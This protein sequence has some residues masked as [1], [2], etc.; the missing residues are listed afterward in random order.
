MSLTIRFRAAAQDE[1]DAAVAWY[2]SGRTGLGDQFAEAVEELLTEVANSPDRYPVIEGDIHEAPVKGFP[3]C[4]YYRVRG[5]TLV[6]LAVY[7]QSRDPEG[8]RDRT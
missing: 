2:E 6:V 1:F 5:G 8:W 7:H 4:V 3:Y